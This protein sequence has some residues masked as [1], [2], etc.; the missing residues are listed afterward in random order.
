MG[1]AQPREQ[2]SRELG[3][4]E[5]MSKRL[6]VGLGLRAGLVGVGL[7]AA[8]CSATGDSDST[9]SVR[10]MLTVAVPFRIRAVDFTAFHDSDTVHEGDCGSGP[11]DQQAVSDPNGGTCGVAFTKAGE[12]LEYSLNVANSGQFNV[13]SRVAGNA[14]GKTFRLLVDG[15][16]VGGSQSVPNAGWQAFA[17][18]P[19]SGVSLSAGSHTLRF[20][21]ETGDTNLNY[22]D[23]TPSAI[24]LPSRVEAESYQR[25]FES[26]PAANS[27]TAC[28]R[29]DGVDKSATADGGGGC[30]VGWLRPPQAV[31]CN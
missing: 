16:A 22:I 28:D 31:R 5:M 4:T 12:W 19:V 14:T 3:K 6:V 30:V 8:A 18:R 13:I 20:L 27:G 23:V 9:S 7:A 26:T 10:E 11:V 17:D 21:F 1:D 24:T 25:A 29:G 15:V 2:A